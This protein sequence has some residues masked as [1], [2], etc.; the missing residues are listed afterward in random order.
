MT[1]ANRIEVL[2]RTA[3]KV[4]VA[5]EYDIRAVDF[6]ELARYAMVNPYS[7]VHLA[8]KYGYA[9]GGRAAKAGKYKERRA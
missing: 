2:Q 3:N 8:Y 4:Q 1:Q 5:S 6:G 7:A 9:K